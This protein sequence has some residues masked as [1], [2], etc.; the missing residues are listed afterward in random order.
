MLCSRVPIL[1]SHKITR[2]HKNSRFSNFSVLEKDNDVFFFLFILFFL[3]S[4]WKWKKM[5]QLQFIGWLRGLTFQ[6]WFDF[7]L[8]LLFKWFKSNLKCNSGNRNIQSSFATFFWKFVTLPL[9]TILCIQRWL[10]FSSNFSDLMFWNMNCNPI[11]ANSLLF[12]WLGIV[13]H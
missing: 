4:F 12:W 9:V 11:I 6:T 13:K 2:A 7:F 3:V 8:Q 1:M 5:F 10:F